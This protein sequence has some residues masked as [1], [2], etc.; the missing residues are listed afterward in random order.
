MYGRYFIIHYR[1]C[2]IRDILHAIYQGGIKGIVIGGNVAITHL[3]FVD[4][5]QLF[6]YGSWRDITKIK[7][8]LSL[9]SEATGMV[10]NAV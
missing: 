3:L 6:T 10:C 7:A 2:L 8:S 9:F 1:I 5:I 4:D